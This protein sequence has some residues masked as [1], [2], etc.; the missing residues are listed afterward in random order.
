MTLTARTRAGYLICVEGKSAAEA[1]AVVAQLERPP[2]IPFRDASQVLA[3][4]PG[5][6]YLVSP[7][8]SLRAPSAG[9][10]A[11]ALAR[12]PRV[13][14]LQKYTAKWSVGQ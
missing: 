3:T 10:T 7:D 11:C 9:H 5:W 13:I 8:S 14:Y 1:S 2:F 4:P 6:G 12:N